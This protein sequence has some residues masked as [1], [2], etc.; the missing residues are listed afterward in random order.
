MLTWHVIVDSAVV[1]ETS[2]EVL[3]R[4]K[5]EEVASAGGTA[6]LTREEGRCGPA[7]KAPAWTP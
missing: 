4:E 1:L 2:N 3:A 7:P 6:I 5:A